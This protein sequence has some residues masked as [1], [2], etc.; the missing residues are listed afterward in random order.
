MAYMT[1]R[2]TSIDP[3][4]D[5][6]GSGSYNQDKD[7]IDESL[8]QGELINYGLTASIDSISDSFVT[9]TGLVGMD[10]ESIGRF[11]Y[12]LDADN[13]FNNGYFQI[14]SILSN[15]SVIIRNADAAL[16]E[17]NNGLIS[18]EEREP[19]S[20]SD[21]IDFARTDRKLIKGTTDFFDPIPTYERPD[22]TN[23]E[24]PANLY[25]I[26]GK[27]LDAHTLIIN[28][29]VNASINAGDG[30]FT[31]SEVG[32]LKHAD[33]INNLGI[34]T[35]DGFDLNNYLSCYVEIIDGTNE[36]DAG[37]QVLFG[38]NKGQRLFG[39]TR[40]GNSVSPNSIEIEFRSVSPGADL[41]TSIAYSWEASQVPDIYLFY[42]YRQR[43]DLLNENDLRVVLTSGIIADSKIQ[44]SIFNL[45]QSIA[46]NDGYSLEIRTFL[47]LPDGETN[48]SNLINNNTFYYV[49]SALPSESTV[50]DALNLINDKI[51]NLAYSP[52]ATSN[53]AGLASNQTVTQS[54]EALAN[55]IVST[56]GLTSEQ[57]KTLRHAIH[58]IPNGPYDGY[59]D[60]YLSSDLYCT[61]S[62]IGNPFPTQMIWYTSPDMFNKIIELNVIYNP[63]KTISSSVYFIYDSSNNIIQTITESFQYSGIFVSNVTRTFT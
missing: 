53:I 35:F 24:T 36:T 27:T 11:L 45:E 5:I 52:S 48:L 19:Y 15:S 25:N 59:F 56:G 63:N 30:Y 26:A 47:G 39:L 31:L 38:P 17:A 60:G 4:L 50:V 12:L 28:K 46:Q 21:D 55:A 44:G 29:R 61:I 6:R 57:H 40:T 62:P 33:P 42:P 41:S 3:K 18:W 54:I 8:S 51:G 14:V 2:Q 9:V 16:P 58:L 23:V 32:T 22:S 13:A 49:L 1:F 43:M 20:I 7:L 34:P 10:Q 37:L